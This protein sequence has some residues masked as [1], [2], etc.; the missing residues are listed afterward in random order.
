MKAMCVSIGTV[1]Y[2]YLICRFGYN[3]G[4]MAVFMI[5]AFIVFLSDLNKR[6]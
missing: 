3:H 1:L 6:S 4:V 5:V 2:L